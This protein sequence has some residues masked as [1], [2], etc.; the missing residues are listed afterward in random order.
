LIPTI[1]IVMARDPCECTGLLLVKEKKNVYDP[2]EDSADA[3]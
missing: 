2:T 3:I 1:I